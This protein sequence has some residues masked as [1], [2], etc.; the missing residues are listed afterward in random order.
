MFRRFPKKF[1]K[2]SDRFPQISK[3]F[4]E[5]FFFFSKDFE[6]FRKVSERF[7]EVSES[8]LKILPRGVSLSFFF[9]L[10]ARRV[11]RCSGG[12]GARVLA[13]CRAT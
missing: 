7:R 11:F 12:V 13:P 9:L 4:Y 3:G 8:Y 6:G 2:G 5:E 10:R 1:P